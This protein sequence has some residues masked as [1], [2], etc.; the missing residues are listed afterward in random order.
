MILIMKVLLIQPPIRDFYLT[1]KRTIPYGLASIAA[2]LEK[3]NI[4]VEIFDC[5]ST[6]KSKII[7]L[8]QE[9][10]YLKKFYSQKDISPF[11]LFS[12]FKHFGYSFQHI[13]NMARK[14]QA[15]VIGISSLFTAYSQ[16][17]LRTAEVVKKYCPK[18]KIVMGGHHPTA[19][20]EKVMECKAIDFVLRGEGEVS[21]PLFVKR[22]HNN[23]D[24]VDIPG[25]VFRKTDKSLHINAP[26]IMNDL[27]SY[28]QASLH[29][30]KQS[31]YQRNKKGST[32]IVASRGCPLK[33]SYCSV[34]STKY[35][36]RSVESVFQEIKNA[37]YKHNVRFID[38]ED[39]NLSLNKKWFMNLLTKIIDNLHEMGIELR[40]MNGLFPP[41]L[42]EEIIY[43][44]K[45]AGFNTL[46]LS[47]GTTYKDQLKK[48]NR[49]D[50][51]HDLEKI[52]KIAD[53]INLKTVTYIIIG[54]PGQRA[55]DS[56]KDLKFISQTTSL[57]GISVYYPTP[58]SSDYELLKKLNILPD[59][60]SMMRSSALPL[61]HETK[62][63]ETVTL[64]RLGRII[65]FIKDLKQS[66][67]TGSIQYDIRKEAGK[68]LLKMFFNDGIIRGMTQDGK[69]FT[70]KTDLNI[71]VQANLKSDNYFQG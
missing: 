48:F 11:A 22:L 51:S 46:N 1:A 20:P 10:D 61:D 27:N 52:Y 40:A 19:L 14:S 53:K 15:F 17:A 9:F 67:D 34:G 58:G 7:D 38:F 13:G 62:R 44:M 30:I 39:E 4:E 42:D 8:P 57:V 16:E 26:A 35:R 55:E 5:L 21:M 31:F 3:N 45:K 70:H 23:E 60:L 33:C 28:P 65:N 66:N 41:S 69:V 50:V 32:V 54:A 29:L 24:L 43:T 37:V 18:A 2:S 71:L 64:L 59:H 12:D 6:K 63:L 25:I 47:L 49:P 68:K 36:Q 56:I